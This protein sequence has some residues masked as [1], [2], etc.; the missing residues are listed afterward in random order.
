MSNSNQDP[1]KNYS[2]SIRLFTCYNGFFPYIQKYF[3]EEWIPTWFGGLSSI[4]GHPS[5]VAISNRLHLYVSDIEN[6]R[7]QKFAHDG[8]TLLASFGKKGRKLGEFYKPMDLAISWDGSTLYVADTGNKRIQRFFISG[9]TREDR[10]GALDVLDS[11]VSI[12]PHPSSEQTESTPHSELSQGSKP[13]ATVTPLPNFSQKEL[14]SQPLAS[15]PVYKQ[16]MRKL[17]SLSPGDSIIVDMGTEKDVYNVGD[18]F[19]MRFRVSKDS[20]VTIMHISTTGDITFFAPN[21][22]VPEAKV[23]GGRVYSTLYDFKLPLEVAPPGGYETINLFCNIEKIDLFDAD[24][25]KE[26]FYSI[27]HDDDERLRDL[28]RRLEELERHEWSGNSV[29]IE[30]NDTR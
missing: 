8:G 20:Y 22:I 3:D 30:I 13:Q 7:I 24:F 16:V 14:S 21:S 29:T 9:P 12:T 11:Q 23:E 28:L 19:E 18:S 17:E 15:S 5:G 10:S 1:T 27:K 6:H 26:G 4:L 2:R 25:A